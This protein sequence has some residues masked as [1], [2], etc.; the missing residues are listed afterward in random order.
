MTSIDNMQ[1]WA[2]TNDKYRYI[3]LGID[4]FSRYA[5]AR[6]LKT[7]QGHNVCKAIEEILDEA[8]HHL[9]RKIK[10]IHC[11]EGKEF[12]NKHVGDLLKS[13]FITMF[14]TKSP[15]KAQMVERLIRTLRSRQERINTFKGS[16]R[17]TETFPQLV[18]S[19]NKTHH[20][21]LPKNMAPA[22]VNL[23]NERAVWLYLYED[24][25]INTPKS[26]QKEIRALK[27][28]KPMILNTSTKSLN[29]GTPVRISKVKRLFEKAYYQNWT[30]ELFFISSI[31]STKPETFRL[32]DSD[33]EIIEGL[34]YKEELQPIRFGSNIKGQ[35]GQIFAIDNVLKE[36]IRKDGKKH[37]LV[38]WRGFPASQN[39]WVRS[40]QFASISRAT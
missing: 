28:G 36:E 2:S 31:S 33:G 39:S 30:D 40:D 23:H 34:F 35:K 6:P 25:M 9:D 3:L 8:E 21:S 4:C 18:K 7:K 38:S 19:Y 20:S 5:Y 17:W 26:L 16:R 13:K 27:K 32:A 22:D 37:M 29:I 14:S 1:K 12:Y 10:T 15:T 11:D 24:E